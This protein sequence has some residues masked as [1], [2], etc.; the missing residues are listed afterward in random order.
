MSIALS[1]CAHISSPHHIILAFPCAGGCCDADITT[2]CCECVSRSVTH[3]HKTETGNADLPA[4][5]TDPDNAQLTQAS[6]WL[7]RQRELYNKQKLDPVKLRLLKDVLGMQWTHALRAL[8]VF[9][10]AG[11]LLVSLWLFCAQKSS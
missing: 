9:L 2:P 1:V 8:L 10:F 5:Y 11:C 7:D 3:R 4:G 6:R